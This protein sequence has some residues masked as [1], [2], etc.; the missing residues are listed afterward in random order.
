MAKDDYHVI[1]YQILAYL[2]ECLKK[3]KKV[4]GNMLEATSPIIMVNDNYWKYIIC[5]LLKQGFIE[6]VTVTNVYGGDCI[7]SD[8]DLAQIT[9][10]GIEYLCS[11]SFMSKAKRF[12]KDIASIAPLLFS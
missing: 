3:G 4:N 6:N 9:P 12:A 11:N 1:V 7:I 8:L 10:I 2:Y 5:N